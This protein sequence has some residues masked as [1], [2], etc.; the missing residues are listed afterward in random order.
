MLGQE[1]E[2]AAATVPAIFAECPGSVSR[3]LSAG[4]A[5]VGAFLAHPSPWVAQLSG[6]STKAG[7]SPLLAL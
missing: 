3:G 7:S 5:A 4:L 2:V 1:I 6:D